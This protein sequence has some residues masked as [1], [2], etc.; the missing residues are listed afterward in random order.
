[1]AT[2]GNKFV[3]VIAAIVGVMAALVF[4]PGINSKNGGSDSS[5]SGIS[6]SSAPSSSD[7]L[8]TLDYGRQNITGEFLPSAGTLNQTGAPSDLLTVSADGSAKFMRF[9]GNSSLPNEKDFSLTSD[10]MSRLRALILDTGFLQIPDA[11]YQ[12]LDNV[13]NYSR[14][15]LDIHIVNSRG[16]GTSGDNS[17]G[18]TSAIPSS[19]TKTI[20]WVD[21][22]ATRGVVPPIIRNIGSSLDSI[23]SSHT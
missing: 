14:Y 16:F 9:N 23:I 8:I 13:T 2:G 12:R 7:V 15:S 6:Q 3:I 11:D 10:E 19:T 20:A 4:L 18:L 17:S 1:M 21:V 22:N 5:N